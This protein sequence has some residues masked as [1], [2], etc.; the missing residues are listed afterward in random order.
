[1]FIE[2]RSIIIE[3]NSER[4]IID[5]PED[6]LNIEIYFKKVTSSKRFN[7]FSQKESVSVYQ[8]HI[9]EGYN[10]NMKC[11]KMSQFGR[12]LILYS[13]YIIKNFTFENFEIF[14]KGN[15]ILL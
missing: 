7:L 11:I 5:L 12:Y 2:D 1:M 15:K 3:P 10:I 14:H 6:I 4:I 13:N 9:S 8:I